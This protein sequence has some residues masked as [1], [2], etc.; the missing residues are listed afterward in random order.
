MSNPFTART[1]VPMTPQNQHASAYFLSSG[2]TLLGSAA[3]SNTNDSPLEHCTKPLTNSQKFTTKVAEMESQIAK[4]EKTVIAF[5]AEN[6]AL[7]HE[8][9][10]MAVKF[11][12]KLGVCVS[13]SK[14][15]MIVN[16]QTLEARV[17]EKRK[18]DPEQED[19]MEEDVVLKQEMKSMELSEAAAHDNSLLV[20]CKPSMPENAHYMQL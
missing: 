7:K 9:K 8:M 4:L 11:R 3:P 14:I 5:Q 10:E 13:Q 2:L 17:G 1:A 6:L 15:A 19:D 20:S 18:R 16:M 12:N